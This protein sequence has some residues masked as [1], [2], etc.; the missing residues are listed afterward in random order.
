VILL[1]GVVSAY[2]T[3]NERQA[4][5]QY[6]QALSSLGHTD[7]RIDAAIDALTAVRRDLHFL[8]S[9][10]QATTG[11]R[12]NSPVVAWARGNGG[13][14]GRTA[15]AKSSSFSVK[16]RD[17]RLAKRVQPPGDR[18]VNIEFRPGMR[19]R[20]IQLEAGPAAAMACRGAP[21]RGGS[22]RTAPGTSS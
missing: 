12:G 2:L 17:E 10:G 6:D 4:N 5:T 22:T 19:A 8:N 18:E 14:P 15:K 11:E 3:S 20:R 16:T 13:A 21:W 9:Q 7:G 1:I